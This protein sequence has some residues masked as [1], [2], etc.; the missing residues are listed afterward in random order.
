MATGT[1]KVKTAEELKIELEKARQKLK[2]LEQRAYAGELVEMVKKSNIVA[3]FN[4]I[5]ANVKGVSELV[6][7]AAI[8]KAVG[9]ARVQ[10]SQSP[11]PKRSAADPNKPKKAAA[12]TGKKDKSA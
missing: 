1:R 11:A 4:A 3:D 10:V 5:K 6:I 8:G 2:E 7:L 12:K 9:I